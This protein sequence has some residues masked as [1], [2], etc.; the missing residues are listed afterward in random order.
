MAHP[1]VIGFLYHVP[2]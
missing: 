1:F 2:W